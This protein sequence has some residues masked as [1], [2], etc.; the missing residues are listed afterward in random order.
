MIHLT[1]SDALA[2]SRQECQK[3]IAKIRNVKPQDYPDWLRAAGR[4]GRQT[5]A[6]AADRRRKA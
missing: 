6:T 2:L 3:Y 4:D 1:L 5:E